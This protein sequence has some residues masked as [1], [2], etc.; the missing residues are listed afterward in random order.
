MSY[1]TG[2]AVPG[3]LVKQDGISISDPT[4]TEGSNWTA[5]CVITGH[6]VV[7][8]HGMADFRSGDHAFFMGEVR[9]EIRLRHADATET[10]LGDACDAVSMYDDC[11]I[12]YI[13]QI[14]V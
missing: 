11:R 9:G 10:S 13:T 2:R 5:S 1:I 12:V 6:L 3:M 8:P 14:G 4:Q 7:M